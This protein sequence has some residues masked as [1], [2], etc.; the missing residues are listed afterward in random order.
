MIKFLQKNGDR[1][2]T[3]VIN[4]SILKLLGINKYVEITSDGKR[5]FIEPLEDFNVEKNLWR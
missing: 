2:N 1:Y 5:I 3:I 4:K